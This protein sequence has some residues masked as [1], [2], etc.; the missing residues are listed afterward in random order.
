MS[1]FKFAC[2]VCGQHITCDSGSSGSPMACPTCFRNL[3]VPQATVPGASSLV[4]SASEVQTRT[5]PLPGTGGA[6]NGRAVPKKEFPWAALALGV[7]VCM[8]AATAFVFR[9]RLL[10]AYQQAVRVA[11][12]A[13][14]SAPKPEVAAVPATNWTLNL[15]EAKIP[16]A[17]AAGQIN[18]QSFTLL[19]ATVMSDLLILW[20]G[21]TWPP[22]AGVAV[23]LSQFA[24]KAEELADKTIS[25]EATRTNAPRMLLRWKDEQGQSVTRDFHEGYALRVEFGSLA[26]T[27]LPGKIYVAAP[28]EAKS[29]VAGTFEL[30]IRKPSSPKP[31]PQP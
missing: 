18:G 11:T 14:P 31:K 10:S 9:A 17:T 27:R 28:D 24:K 23:S 16:A 15:A 19:G 3:V 6:G 29:Y 1:E 12:N 8:V 5:T 30:E 7:V 21:T 2:P 4:L 13:P 26:G 22:D 20:P 25:I